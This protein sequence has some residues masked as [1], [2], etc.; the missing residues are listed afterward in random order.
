MDNGIHTRRQLETLSTKELDALINRELDQERPDGALIGQIMEIIWEREKDLPLEITPGI[1]AA[2][3]RYRERIKKLDDLERKRR[4]R[5]GF[6]RLAYTAA[7]LSLLIL[8]IPREVQAETLFE[9][10]TRWS[11]SV[12]EFFSPETKN[13]NK[14]QYRF[15]TENPGLQQVYDTLVSL[16]VTEPVVPMWLPEGYELEGCKKIDTAQKMGVTAC[17]KDG[18]SQLIYKIDVYDEDVSHKY[19]KDGTP[20]IL[21][22]WAGV[23][24]TI[25]KNNDLWVVIWFQDKTECFLT[26]DCPEETLYEILRSIYVTEDSYETID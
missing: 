15:E 25:L 4:W 26:L 24:H 3:D 13:E 7:V 8:A 20:V 22:D 1:Q 2:W 12:V 11:A 6:L 16:G 17:F 19:H 18:N 21:Y 9:K 23:E 5:A 14:T 10:L